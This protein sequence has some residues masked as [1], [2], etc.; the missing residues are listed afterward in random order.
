ME[1]SAFKLYFGTVLKTPVRGR[2]PSNP[3]LLY[4]Q[5]RTDTKDNKVSNQP[6]SCQVKCGLIQSAFETEIEVIMIS[7]APQI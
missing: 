2:A 7:E 6:E 3:N 5:D 1:L 4:V